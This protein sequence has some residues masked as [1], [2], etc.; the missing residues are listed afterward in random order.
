MKIL[1]CDSVHQYLVDGLTALG[2]QVDIF[3]DISQ[4]SLLALIHSYEGL[5]VNTRNPVNKLLIDSAPHL[6]CVARLGSGKEILDLNEL[7]KRKIKVITSPEANCNA[8][9][10]H[11]LGMLLCLF[12]N[13]LKANLELRKFEWNREENRGIEIKGKTISIIGYGHTGKRFTQLLS[14]F[15]C[16]IKIY[17]K[18]VTPVN[19]AN[20]IEVIRDLSGIYDSDIISYHVSYMPENFHIFSSELINRMIKPFY[21]VNT[22]RGMVVNT[23]DLIKGIEEGKVLG[24]CL[25][26][27][28]NE[29]PSSFSEEEQSVFKQ[30]MNKP[31][32]IVTP[33]IAGWTVESKLAI[34]SSILSQW[35]ENK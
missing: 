14:A 34:A 32:V 21:L 4:S 23:K 20:N 28:E 7:S 27:F 22:S 31:Q 30:L 8:V 16:K 24:A 3:N 35:P 25:D 11:A 29:K 12:R 19:D 9:A 5:I 18:Y 1:I 26:V 2:H 13:I 6:A 17:D 15:D 33:H 10:E